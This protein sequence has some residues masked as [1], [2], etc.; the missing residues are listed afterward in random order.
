MINIREYAINNSDILKNS[1]VRKVDRI[2]LVDE[3]EQ[4]Q[5]KC[6]C[7]HV[8]EK[9]PG[10]VFFPHSCRVFQ[11]DVS[12]NKGQEWAMGNDIWIIH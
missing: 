11:L 2:T 10:D 9:F 4:Q 5:Q 8:M 7:G 6:H 3:P 1:V 12:E